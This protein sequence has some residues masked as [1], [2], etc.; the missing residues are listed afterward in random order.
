MI[1]FIIVI[2]VKLLVI[3]FKLTDILFYDENIC[4]IISYD[5]LKKKNEKR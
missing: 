5:D 2:L 3:I 4:N 1:I